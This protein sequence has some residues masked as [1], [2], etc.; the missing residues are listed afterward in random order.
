MPDTVVVSVD[1]V[2]GIVCLAIASYFRRVQLSGW[3]SWDRASDPAPPSLNAGP[4]P[5]TSARRGCVGIAGYW[6]AWVPILLFGVAGVLLIL[7]QEDFVD[8]ISTIASSVVSP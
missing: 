4:S 1:V 7:M 3:Q 8:Y 6:F 2:F 5:L